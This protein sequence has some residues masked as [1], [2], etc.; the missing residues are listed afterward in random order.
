[1]MVADLSEAGPFDITKAV[2]LTDPQIAEMWVDLPNPGFAS[3]IK[4]RSPVPQIILG[5]KGSGRTH[6][7][8]YYSYHL[9]KLRA[10]LGSVSEALK[11]DRYIGVFMRCEGL[12]AGRFEGKGQDETTWSNLFAYY[13]DLW[14]AELVIL[15]FQDAFGDDAEM[16]SA[17]RDIATEITQ[18]FDDES[19]SGGDYSAVK[20]VLALLRRQRRFVDLAVNNAALTHEIHGV[21]VAA[22]RGRL[23]FG[24][25]R[26][27]L[28]HLVSLNNVH[29]VYLIDELEN[30]NEYQQKYINTLIREKQHPSTFK[31][32]SRLYGFRTRS[33]LSAGEEN[34]INSEYEQVNL[35]DE[36]RARS[37]DYRDFAH[38]LVVRRLLSNHVRVPE[39]ADDAVAFVRSQFETHKSRRLEEEQTRFL[40]ER[41]PADERPY[42]VRLRNQLEEAAS[43]G[44]AV[45]VASKSDV[46][47][48]GASLRVGD[49]LLL[50]KVNIFLLYQ[51]WSRK[52]DLID[53]AEMIRGEAA[54]FLRGERGTAQDRVLKYFKMDLFAQLLRDYR[55]Q[56]RYLG[57]DCFVD[58]SSAIPRHLLI[59]LKFIYRWSL[60]Y[61]E[62]P[63]GGR[64]IGVAAQRSGVLEAATWFFEDA[65]SVGVDAKEVQTGI[66]RLAR[67]LRLMRFADKPVESSLA[68]FSIDR[69]LASDRARRTIQSAVDVS[70]LVHFPEGHRDRNDRGLVQKYQLNPMV[71]PRFDLPLARRGVLPLTREE[72]EAIF[73]GGSGDDYETAVSLRVSRMNAPFR[74]MPGRRSANADAQGELPGF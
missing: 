62:E 3:L 17:D 16:L 40:L 53:S 41:Y 52:R 56:Q 74:A 66:E 63:F 28:A 32:G 21:R 35:D 24:V 2:D 69:E 19:I 7:L 68:S 42:L 33:T 45:G 49:N 39:G 30:F 31:V 10:G 59:V 64:P 57:F 14:L 37:T 48:I 8:R 34:R 43:S 50:E 38:R 4:P 47:R 73:G 18:L 5:G 54:A 27:F 22:S 44:G 65:R 1:M 25:P 67:L 11:R 9:Q 51:A 6:L 72:I 46:R 12:N 55:Q 23:V 15:I 29:V 20:D 26:A 36:L 60:F 61:G 13:M 58:M 70:L 71:C